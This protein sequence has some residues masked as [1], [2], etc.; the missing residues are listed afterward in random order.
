MVKEIFENLKKVWRC[1]RNFWGA[2]RR[3]FSKELENKQAR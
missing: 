3:P 1:R 2:E